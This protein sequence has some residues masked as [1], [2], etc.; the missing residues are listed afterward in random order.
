M[1]SLYVQHF[2]SSSGLPPFVFW[3]KEEINSTSLKPWLLGAFCWEQSQSNVT[4]TLGIHNQHVTDTL[5]EGKG[6]SRRE[7]QTCTEREASG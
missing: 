4:W 2:C 1:G 6:Q 5:A 3:N 7:E